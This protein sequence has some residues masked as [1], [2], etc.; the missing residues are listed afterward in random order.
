MKNAQPVAPAFLK[1]FFIT[2]ISTA[3]HSQDVSFVGLLPTYTQVTPLSKKVDWS[4]F[5][6]NALNPG[7]RHFGNLDYPEADIR[8]QLNNGIVYKA[9]KNLSFAAG[10]LYQKNFA[11]DSRRVDEY[12]AYQQVLFSNYYDALKVS[13]RFRFCERFIENRVTHDYPLTTVLQYNTTLLVPFKGK[14]VAPKSFYA[15][16]YAEEFFFLSG[17]NKFSFLGE[18]WTNA[19]IGYNFGQWGKVQCGFT[20]EW[21]VRNAAKDKREMYLFS[22]E[23]ITNFDLFSVRKQK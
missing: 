13:H 20:Y 8:L 17:P 15:T 6:G 16:G 4:F 18:F 10:M 3:A 11:F 9:Q 2:L 22:T 5:F 14:T 21:L 19:S 23:L 7:D 12:R 1:I